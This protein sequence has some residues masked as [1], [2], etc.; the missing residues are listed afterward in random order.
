MTPPRM[1]KLRLP[2]AAYNGQKTV[3]FT[4]CELHRRPKLADPEIVRACVHLLA[5]ATNEFA[6]PSRLHHHA[7]LCPRERYLH[8]R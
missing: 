6:R 3:S 4:A 2:E 1:K 7:G 8:G 5:G